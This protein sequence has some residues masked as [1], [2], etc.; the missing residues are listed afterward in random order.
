MIHYTYI[1]E[2]DN[3][4]SKDKIEVSLHGSFEKIKKDKVAPTH[5]KE[6]SH[7]ITFTARQRQ[8]CLMLHCMTWS[9]AETSKSG[10]PIFIL[11]M[12]REE[13]EVMMAKW[14]RSIK[15]C[16]EKVLI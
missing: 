9:L 10:P 7:G 8:V 3:E 15:R 14:G 5:T 4:A 13:E 1:K 2:S 6:R 16:V 12:R 11:L